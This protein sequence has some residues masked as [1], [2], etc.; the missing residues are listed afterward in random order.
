MYTSIVLQPQHQTN[1]AYDSRLILRLTQQEHIKHLV[2]H[3]E[4]D[5]WGGSEGALG[6][7]A[8]AVAGMAA[9][10]QSLS[11]STKAPAEAL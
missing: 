11:A 5:L 2:Q 4:A 7:R 8:E 3:A 10:C 6:L 9:A 1:G